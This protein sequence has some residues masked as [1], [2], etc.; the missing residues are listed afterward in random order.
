MNLDW[1]HCCVGVSETI[2]A[3]AL[4]IGSGRL[5]IALV[6]DEEGRL[7]GTV[8]DGDIRRAMLE[9]SSLED[10]VTRCMRESFSSVSPRTGRAEVLDLMHAHG[11]SQIPVLDQFGKVLGIHTMR[12]ISGVEEKS[13]I[14]VIMAGGRGSRLGKLTQKTPKPMLKVAGRPILERLV[15][16]LVGHGIRKIYLS[17]HYLAEMIEGHFGDGKSL[18]CQIEYLREEEP[19]GT[20]GCLS[21]L[22]ET[23]MHDVLLCNGDLVTQV[24]FDAMLRFHAEGGFA[25]TVGASPYTHSIPFGVLRRKGDCL[26]SIEEKPMLA[27]EINAGVYVLSPRVVVEIPKRFY[28]ITEAISSLLDQ[29]QQVGVYSIEDD[30]IDVGERE[31][32]M[33]ARGEALSS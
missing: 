6:L 13:N 26:E 30:W 7:A 31:Q 23:P 10:P 32:L 27:H 28:P 9:K 25:V 29:R 4:A 22:P 12:G 20:G 16:H 3:A 18:G 8:T 15:L 33:K 11:I 24:D 21:L 17:V 1:K 2:R 14:A 5:G 19:L